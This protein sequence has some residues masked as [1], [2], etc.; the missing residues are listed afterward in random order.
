MF[1][2]WD[3]DSREQFGLGNEIVPSPLIPKRLLDLLA[4]FHFKTVAAVILGFAYSTGC[5]Y[6]A[7]AG[8]HNCCSSFRKR[9]TVAKGFRTIF[10]IEM[11]W[12]PCHK[13]AFCW[14]SKLASN[15]E[16][17][18][19]STQPQCIFAFAY[20]NVCCWAG[21]LPKVWL[22][23]R[24]DCISMLLLRWGRRKKNGSTEIIFLLDSNTFPTSCLLLHFKIAAAIILISCLVFRVFLCI[25][26]S[27]RRG[28]TA[29]LSPRNSGYRIVGVSRQ[30]L[31]MWAG[32]DVPAQTTF[33][34]SGKRA[35]NGKHTNQLQ[36]TGVGA[37][38][39]A[40]VCRSENQVSTL[41][42]WAFMLLA[43][44]GLL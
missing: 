40:V 17:I 4:F 14:S 33:C 30:C 34:W 10:R 27:I 13:A 7:S 32:N 11:V 19:A 29:A 2:R 24:L 20:Y 6:L 36:S 3:R 21:S 8:G 42:P 26:L 1:L 16:G 41:F 38:W 5:S 9:H 12:C 18:A 37:S 31:K 28:I 35:E 39:Q 43:M 22:Q 15:D 23:Q 44:Q 25:S